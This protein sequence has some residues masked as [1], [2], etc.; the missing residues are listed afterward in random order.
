MESAV[1]IER[2]FEVPEDLA[3]P[4][5]TGVA[6]VARVVDAGED[7]LEATYFDTTDLRL[8]TTGVTV[9]RRTGGGDEGW[10]LKLPTGSDRFE[11]R[12]PLSRAK[13]T[14][15]KEF[16][17]ALQSVVG[18]AELRPCCVVRTQRRR[19]HL[20]D[21]EG[22][23]LAEVADDRVTAERV[24][25]V[26][27]AAAA[28]SW[29]EWEVELEA[30]GR[31]LLGEVASLLLE[32][33]A[34]E[35][36]W[37]SKLARTLGV[38]V[39]PGP[40]RPPKAGKKDSAASV[41]ERRF[42]Y[43]AAQLRLREVAVRRDLPDGVHQ[44]RVTVRRLR[45]LLATA[46]P[47]LDREVSEPLRAE[48]QWLGDLLGAPRDAEVARDLVLAALEEVPAEEVRGDLRGDLDRAF[49]EEYAAGYAP[50]AEALDSERYRA[51]RDSLERFVAQPPWRGRAHTRAD[52]VLAAR[53][54]HEWRRVE[55]R[56]ARAAAVDPADDE[57]AYAARMHAARKAAKRLRY[58]AEAAAPVAGKPAR[59][60]ARQAKRFQ[61]RTGEYNDTHLLRR[62][63]AHLVDTADPDAGEAFTLGVLH[64]R[65]QRHGAQLRRDLPA[66][67]KRLARPKLRRWMG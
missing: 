38:E 28:S 5:L 31:P 10:H 50:L 3:V 66:R 41:L 59:R 42:A 63:L 43:L 65:V 33:G 11:L 53:V 61:S 25:P 51:L 34:T 32:A 18:D 2:K 64:G 14:V 39:P 27:D 16:R 56:A 21:D 13:H 22:R 17:D 20:E 54:A 58:A 47:L 26:D 48:L 36:S 9:R 52:R 40:R 57:E 67:W 29:R 6:G 60:L 62:R 55:K 4:D 46:R 23:V 35:S 49:A 30:G 45:S 12:L 44:L 24:D 19:H 7:E 15:P 8:A 1:E 37:G